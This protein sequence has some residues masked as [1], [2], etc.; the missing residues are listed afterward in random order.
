L[1]NGGY[2]EEEGYSLDKTADFVVECH[3]LLHL[4]VRDG[5]WDCTVDFGTHFLRMG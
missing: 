2:K 5:I 1:D 4:G 3:V